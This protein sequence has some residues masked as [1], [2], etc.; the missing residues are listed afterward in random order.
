MAENGR[1][2]HESGVG[3]VV[4]CGALWERRPRGRIFCV[5]FSMGGRR[6]S[7]PK[8]GWP[9]A[10]HPKLGQLLPS[11]IKT[12]E[13]QPQTQSGK[14]IFCLIVFVFVLLGFHTSNLFKSVNVL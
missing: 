3:F 12:N 7:C 13:K 11:S 6:R 9:V 10:A 1:W 14:A 8:I 5:V 4:S 2:D